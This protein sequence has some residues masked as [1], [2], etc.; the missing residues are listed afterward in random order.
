MW[1]TGLIASFK[2]LVSNISDFSSLY[3]ANDKDIGATL[4]AMFENTANSWKA[5]F[6][7]SVADI[8]ETVTTLSTDIDT[9]ASDLGGLTSPTTPAN[10]TQETQRTTA[11]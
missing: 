4:M 8:E 3:A 5:S 10:T 9:I 6:E 7:N 1:I 2:S 11:P